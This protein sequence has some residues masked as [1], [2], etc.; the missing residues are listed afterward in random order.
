[1]K[2]AI[3]KRYLC[4][5][6]VIL[7]ATPLAAETVHIYVNNHAGTTIQVIDAVTNKIVQTIEGVEAPEGAQP[8]PDGKYIFITSA[9]E[10][11]LTVVDRAANRIIKKVPLSGHANDLAVTKDGK[12]VLI[13]IAE[14]PGAVDVIDTASLTL[15]KSIPTKSRMHDIV[16]TQDGKYAVAGSPEGKSVTVYDLA[17][18]EPVWD[19]ELDRGIMPLTL[20]HRPDGS[21]SRILVN[22]GGFD[23]FAA[24]D[25]DKRQETARVRNPEPRQ[26]GGFGRRSDTSHGIGVAPDN[27]TVWVVSR[28]TNHIYA[29]S[30]P[31]LKLIGQV[32]F[33]VL[34]LP[35]Q[36]PIGASPH[37]ITFTPDSKTV[38][39][40]LD[41]ID[42]I[43]AIDVA[44]RK[45][46]AR[47]KAGIVPRRIS[48]LALP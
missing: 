32:E 27:K 41:A 12:Y 39:V 10:N 40:S 18:L 21:A 43:L 46:V 1:M 44:T 36:K 15:L 5:M 2:L 19:L 16:V 42:E 14:T 7:F 3:C 38:Y 8:S 13:C 45:E 4:Y 37:W 34:Q 6:A 25:F 24:I 23:G 11:V 17:T 20:E 48:T 26:G 30:L 22:L 9:A 33:P 28:V 31:D 35:G 29:Y 47:I